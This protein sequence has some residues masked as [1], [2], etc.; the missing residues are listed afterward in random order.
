ML[1]TF[2]SGPIAI[3]KVDC[4]K[5][6]KIN[7]VNERRQAR[8][9]FTGI[10]PD[11]NEKPFDIIVSRYTLPEV[12]GTSAVSTA[13]GTINGSTHF[14]F[15]G[16]Y[17]ILKS[18]WTLGGNVGSESIKLEH[19]DPAELVKITIKKIQEIMVN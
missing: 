1:I 5:D 14:N 8:I 10:F 2:G 19:S 15:K 9:K 16:T 18:K 4:I 11:G 12:N 6:L 13:F 7:L 17:E 3:D